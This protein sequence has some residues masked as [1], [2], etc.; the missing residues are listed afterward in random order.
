MLMPVT[1]SLARNIFWYCQVR[2]FQHD[3][4]ASQI[5]LLDIIASDFFHLTNMFADDQNDRLR[6][7][8]D[9]FFG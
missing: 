4:K 9:M 1:L 7:H 6:M 2:F 5:L 3:A 8:K